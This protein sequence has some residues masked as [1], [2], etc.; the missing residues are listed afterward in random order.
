M[1]NFNFNKVILGGRL[2]A[3]PELRQT[4]SGLAVCSFNLAINR[5]GGK[6]EDRRADFIPCTAWRER[7][8]FL[9]KYFRKGSSLCV[10]GSLQ[11]RDY[12]DK[13]GNKR[14][15]TEVIVDEIS[16]VDSKGEEKEQTQSAPKTTTAAPPL[17]TPGGFKELEDDGDL[18]F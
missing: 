16:F 7:A 17:Y 10:V 15:A 2:T 18:P 14:Y 13:D 5:K 1:A 12:T 9:S 4:N 8:E 11:V 6:D 3:D